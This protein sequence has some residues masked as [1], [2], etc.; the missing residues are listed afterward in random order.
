MAAPPVPLVGRSTVDAVNLLRLLACTEQ[1]AG[2]SEVDRELLAA[3]LRELHALYRRVDVGHGDVLSAAD[4]DDARRRVRLLDELLQAERSALE[5]KA[6]Q[7]GGL[8]AA[9]RVSRGASAA[10][11]V[12]QGLSSRRTEAA[13]DVGQLSSAEASA[14]PIASCGMLTGATEAALPAAACRR[15]AGNVAG[16]E[17]SVAVRSAG[18]IEQQRRM[19]DALLDDTAEMVAR[20][21]HNSLLAQRALAADNATLDL[22]EDAASGNV[23]KVDA[24]ARRILATRRAMRATCCTNWLIGLLVLALFML[25][26]VFIRLFPAPRR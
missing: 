19:H 26:L 14:T 25:T 4:V 23:S 22:T 10:V 3:H 24:E 7:L 2:A 17:A 1:M 6:V 11:E 15:R 16:E 18:V 21:K 12:E 13:A 8:L 9:T 5:P 20:L